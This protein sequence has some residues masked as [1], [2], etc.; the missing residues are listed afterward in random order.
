M[1]IKIP[2]QP[3]IPYKNWTLEYD[4]PMPSFDPSK[5]SLHLE[6]EQNESYLTGEVLAKRMKD[7]GLNS[8]ALKYL[9]DNPKLIPEEWKGKY[10]YF[11]GTI[12]RSPDGYRYVLYLYW[13]D[14]EWLWRAYWLEDDWRASDPSAVVSDVSAIR[15]KELG[16]SETLPLELV[17]NGI[18]Y[19]RHE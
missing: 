19:T 18:K 6:P 2:L 1:N 3:Y 17:I 11:F 12:L 9:L 15:N 5:L 8:N 10:V 4:N 14:G 7:K 16:T 13:S